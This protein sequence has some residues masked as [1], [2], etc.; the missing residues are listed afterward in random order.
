[1]K[2]FISSHNDDESL[3]GAYTLLREKPLVAIVTD[4]F[5]QPNRGEDGC[6]ADERWQES[7]EACKILGCPVIR[8]AIRDDVLT[9]DDV[10]AALQRF[11]GFEKVYAPAI[12]ENGNWQ[13]N[14]IGKVA[15]ELWPDLTAYTS[16]SRNNLWINGSIEIKPTSEEMEL[17]NRALDCYVSQINLGATRPHFDAVRNHS[18]FYA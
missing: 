14:L 15:R 3:F 6:S 18:E 17:K 16:Y 11:E 8:L 9:E 10:R 1:M 5:I 13:H 4:S 7:V 12:H 2:L